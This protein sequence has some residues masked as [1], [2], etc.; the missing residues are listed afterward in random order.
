[1]TA[2]TVG[3]V[4]TYS[5]ELAAAL[6]PHGVDLI[7]ATMGA[8]LRPEQRAEL[9]EHRNIELYESG[10]RLE[11][12]DDPWPDLERAGEWLLEV[13]DRV[14]PDL[15]HLNG[16]YHA[17]LP[18][19]V[20]VLVVAHSC[21]VTWWSAVKGG[22]AP[23]DW[24]RY[25]A[26]VAYGLAAADLVVTPSSALLVALRGC[27][28]P[29]AGAS[30]ISNARDPSCFPVAQKEPM[31]V[32][33]GRIWDEAKNLA[34]LAEVAPSLSWPVY[35]AGETAQ[36]GGGAG[37]DTGRG[38][39]AGGRA[40]VAG[41]ESEAGAVHYLGRLSAADLA[42]WLG[43]AALYALPARYEPFGLSALEAA[44][45]GCALVLG[46]I[47]SLREVWGDTATFVPPNDA[48]ALHHALEGLIRDEA[49]RVELAGRARAR[50]LE[51]SPRRMGVGYLAAY[52]EAEAR[53]NAG[54][55]VERSCA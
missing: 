54:R 34:A 9:S 12:M 7:L 30:V 37:G 14:D 13:A 53:W 3:G 48:A 2:D 41:G 8:P 1:M 45:A 28:G 15:V 51:Y 33:A 35:L 11:W 29:L 52:A 24:D 55:G 26:G 16:Y 42:G 19:G 44:L 50:A 43:R 47:P 21:V 22:P 46:D 5:L 23:P 36:P 6:A 38:S 32:G 10:Y 18:W 17:A 20:P 4:W 25:R 40:T 27:Y 31:I 39:V 49:L